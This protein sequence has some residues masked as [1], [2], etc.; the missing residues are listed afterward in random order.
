MMAFEN[1]ETA[2]ELTA[3]QIAEI[4]EIFNDML[5]L[6][7]VETKY[8]LAKDG[9]KKVISFN[10][11]ITMNTTNGYDLLI[12]IYNK[13]GEFLADV[14]LTADMFG[15]EIIQETGKDIKEA[16]KIVTEN[17]Q[18]SEAPKAEK[19]PVK[20]VKGAKLPTTASDYAVNTLAGLAFV[21]AGVFLFRRIR[22]KGI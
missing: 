22:A 8:Y 19:S 10:D 15:S 4:F 5:D 13:Q 18:A 12:E 3:E 7:Q 17:N 6:F 1:F 20:T 9:E 16:E 2:E 14:L 21:A 11:L